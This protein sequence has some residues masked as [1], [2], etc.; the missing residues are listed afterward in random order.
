MKIEMFL[1]EGMRS[2]TYTINRL[3]GGV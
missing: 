1:E 3:R 2:F